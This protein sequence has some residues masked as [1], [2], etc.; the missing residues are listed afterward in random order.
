VGHR[1]RR[2]ECHLLSHLVVQVAILRDSLLRGPLRSLP[3]YRLGSPA[4]NPFRYQARRQRL[5][6]LVSRVRSL[7][8]DLRACQVV[9]RL[10]CLLKHLQ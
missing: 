4:D 7:R 1:P 8:I 2:Q 5:C 9:S 6:L 10:R 3:E